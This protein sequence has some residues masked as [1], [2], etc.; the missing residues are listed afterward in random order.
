[1]KRPVHVMGASTAILLG[2]MVISLSSQ[3][4]QSA[5]SLVVKDGQQLFEH[6]TFG[7]NGR[8]CLT[9][10]SRE[11]GTISPQDAQQR[12]Q[13][14]PNDPLFLHDGSDDG[15]GNG[16]TRMLADATILVEV[17]LPPNVRLADDPSARSVVLRRGIPTTLNTPALD[18]VLMID[19]RQPTLEAQAHGAI[20]DHAQ[21][22]ISPDADDLTAIKNFQLTDAFFSSPALRDFARGG[23]APVLPLGNTESEKRGRRFFEDLPPGPTFKDGLC[24]ACH[25]GPMLNQTNQ[26][27][28][29]AGVT[30]GSR[31]Q[32]V[33]VSEFNAAGNP[34]REYIFT[35]PDG[36][37]TRVSSPDPGRALVT[38][39]GLETGTFDNVNAFKISPL[40]GIR[41]TAPYF[42]DNSAKTLEA[43]A[44]HYALF[45]SF[46]TDPDGPGPAQP[47]I[48]LT[49]QD[50]ADIVAYMK[51]LE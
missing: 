5:V 3:E 23:P 36:T 35:N 49:P 44:A 51:L 37:E 11:T 15:R 41:R 29:I 14:D 46:A 13:N 21:P 2:A 22:T 12:L 42:H 7:G 28:P 18:N 39:V 31:F 16:V 48:L 27:L 30:P 26:F 20:L 34:V 32:T 40:W 19:G 4:Q 17:P 6:E 8:T 25:S 1:M 10:H 45:F 43:V 50:Q 24:A 33:G 47:L 38:G 9:C